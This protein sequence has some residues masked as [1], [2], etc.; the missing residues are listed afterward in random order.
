MKYIFELAAP[1]RD[2]EDLFGT[3]VTRTIEADG[4]SEIGNFFWL[5]KDG[6]TVFLV[7]K[8]RVFTVDIEA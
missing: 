6:E 4:L 8:D 5:T 2:A 1:F 7:D 3:K